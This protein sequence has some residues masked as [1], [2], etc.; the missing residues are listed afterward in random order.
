MKKALISLITLIIIA[1]GWLT[2]MGVFNTVEVKTGQE[3]GYE[4]SGVF[5]H[6]SYSNIS[7]TFYDMV[8]IADSNGF[9][10]YNMLSIY[11]NNP[12]QVPTD[13][14]LTFVGVVCGDSSELA[15]LTL[16][17]L[18]QI[19]LPKGNAVYS[20]FIYRNKLS[21]AV[22]PI[23]N[24]PALFEV[25]KEKGWDPVIGFEFF[26]RDYTRYVLLN[27]DVNELSTRP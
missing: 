18:T 20:D 12:E 5:H 11:F 27:G 4:L 2:Y 15:A 7:E 14:L 19:S 22:G 26:K 8:A 10:T 1:S 21:H 9:D 25:S 16:D 6:G 24:Y 17:G 23:V 3:G 13:S